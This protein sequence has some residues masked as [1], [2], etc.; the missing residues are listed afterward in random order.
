MPDGASFFASLWSSMISARGRCLA[1]SA[2]K[3]IISTAPIEKFG[4]TKTGTPRSFASAST[5]SR[6]DSQPVVPTTTGS[7]RSS[8][9]SM[10]PTTASGWVKSTAASPPSGIESPIS[11][12]S[13][14]WPAFSS[15]SATTLPT[16][17]S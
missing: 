6:S 9:A 2:A 11:T 16:F 17:P 1:A 5:R 12:P 8:A 15:P 4:A 10:F 14:S 7:P 13:T 3:R